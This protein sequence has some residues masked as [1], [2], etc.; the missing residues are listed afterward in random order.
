MIGIT[1]G[2]AVLYYLMSFETTVIRVSTEEGRDGGENFLDYLYF[3][4]VTILSVGYG[5][6]VPV[7]YA[8]FFALLEAAIGFLLP[9][10]YFVRAINGQSDNPPDIKEGQGN[11]SDKRSKDEEDERK[12]EE[13][14]D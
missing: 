6:L 11:Y 10:A 1:I 2:F 3:S 14:D 8:R 4:G 7:G 9:T 5:D 12:T 13:A